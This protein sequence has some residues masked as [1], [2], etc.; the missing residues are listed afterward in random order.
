MYDFNKVYSFG[1]KIK[2]EIIRF[3]T[4]DILFYFEFCKLHKINIDRNTI[5]KLGMGWILN[6]GYPAGYEESAEK[7]TDSISA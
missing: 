2:I 1:G 3:S 5:T 6:S 4:I 7:K